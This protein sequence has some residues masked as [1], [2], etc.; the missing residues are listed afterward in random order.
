VS[1][2]KGDTWQLSADPEP[3]DAVDVDIQ[4]TSSNTAFVT[5]SDA[6]LVTAVAVGNATITASSGSVKSTP[7][8]VN[9]SLKALT[10]FEVAPATLAGMIVGEDSLLVVT[11]TPADA[12]GSFTFATSNSNVATV[13]DDGLVIAVGAGSAEITV[14]PTGGS[15]AAK[16]VQVTVLAVLQSFTV[17]PTAVYLPVPEAATATEQLNIITTPPYIAGVTFS[18]VS[19]NTNIATVSASGVVTA[20]AAGS[21]AITVTGTSPG[22]ATPVTVNVPVT[23]YTVDAAFN[24]N[25]WTAEATSVWSGLM[26]ANMFDNNINSVWHSSAATGVTLPQGFTVDMH[27]YKQIN[28]FYLYNR[29]DDPDGVPKNM[30]I[31]M[32]VNGTDWTIAYTYT[33]LSPKLLRIVLP[34]SEPPVIAR[35]F[36]VTIIENNKG[37]FYT[38]LAEMGAYNTAEPLPVQTNIAL[39]TPAEGLEQ[40]AANPLTFSW[41][42]D[43]PAP[44]GD[45][46]LK[47]SKNQDLSAATEFTL[48]G[49]SKELTATQLNGILGADDAATFYWTVSAAGFTTPAT[50]SFAIDKRVPIALVNAKRPFQGENPSP[51]GERFQQLVGWTHSST[52]LVS[53]AVDEGTTI[54]MFSSPGGSVP[55]ANNGKV[56]QTVTLGPGN[57][58]LNFMSYKMDGNAG[59]TAY[60]VATT[61]AVPPDI[62]DV[63][64]AQG[65]LGYAELSALPVGNRLVSFTLASSAKVTIGWVYN[66]YSWSEQFG[67]STLYMEG[68]ELWKLP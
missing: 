22:L 28:G 51:A 66:T 67:W 44:T 25:A 24:K 9:V 68:V 18:Y 33:N 38:Y 26:P 52:E 41:E 49:T 4:W 64:T 17:D 42:A 3:A 36:K 12:G 27:G 63:S 39:N 53:Y 23:V 2:A 58:R 10:S 19:A 62:A 30:T 34:L 35:Y 43:D 21:T 1:L 46:T 31:E 55:Y 60:G 6:G 14:T 40:S 29:Q 20:V 54:V 13:S 50:R 37:V 15:V 56:Y 11:K 16:T 45:Y 5:V 47:I 32:S 48:S 59:V 8:T 65:V 7:I 61:Q 57:Y